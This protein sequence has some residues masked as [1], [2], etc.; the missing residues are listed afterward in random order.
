MPAPEA[1]VPTETQARVAMLE[2]G[3]RNV[4]SWLAEQNA[5]SPAFGWRNTDTLSKEQD[6]HDLSTLVLYTKT[7]GGQTVVVLR[8]SVQDM[9]A[10]GTGMPAKPGG[11]VTGRRAG[12]LVRTPATPAQP[13]KPYDPNF[14][15]AQQLINIIK[16][17]YPDAN[18]EFQSGG[19]VGR[20]ESGITSVENLAAPVVS[21]ALSAFPGQG[22]SGRLDPNKP[23]A[24]QLQDI[25]HVKQPSLDELYTQSLTT[26]HQAFGIE[27]AAAVGLKPTDPGYDTYTNA[28]NFISDWYLNPLIIAGKVGEGLHLASRVPT[29]IGSAKGLA[30]LIYDWRGK[31][32]EELVTGSRW[33]NKVT[34]DLHRVII[35]NPE[36]AEEALVR[37]FGFTAN[38][39]KLMATSRSP[40]DVADNLIDH[41]RGLSKTDVSTLL[42]R[43]AEMQRQIASLSKLR[44]EPSGSNVLDLVG[45]RIAA[46]ETEINSI[47]AKLRFDPALDTFDPLRELPKLKPQ[48]ALMMAGKE[49]FGDTALGQW[50]DRHIL[51]PSDLGLPENIGSST[52]RFHIPLPKTRINLNRIMQPVAASRAVR[53]P[54]SPNAIRGDMDIFRVNAQATLADY[55]VSAAEQAKVL[56]LIV[57]SK[58]QQEIYNVMTHEFANA[59]EEATQR[60]LPS[61]RRESLKFFRDSFTVKQWGIL[62]KEGV[63]RA[64]K[65]YTDWEPLFTVETHAPDGTVGIRPQPYLRSHLA[66]EFMFPSHQGILD[67]TGAWRR[68][69][70]KVS[71]K[72]GEK[73]LLDAWHVEQRVLDKVTAFWKNSIL[74]GRPIAV[75]LRTAGEESVR[76]AAAGLAS[77]VNRPWEWMRFVYNS[78]ERMF[79]LAKVTDAGRAATAAEKTSEIADL[80]WFA[81]RKRNALRRERNIALRDDLANPLGYLHN[82]TLRDQVRRPTEGLPIYLRA[83]DEDELTQGFEALRSW[84]YSWH[85][86]ELSR[87]MLQSG[88]TEDMIA[89]AKTEAGQ[90]YLSDVADLWKGYD[91]PENV[92]RAEATGD[93]GA[94][95]KE[96]DRQITEA[97]G[98]AGTEPEGGQ[99]VLMRA[100]R[101]RLAAQQIE[102]GAGEIAGLS[103]ARLRYV[104]DTMREEMDHL[105]GGSEKIK[106]GILHGGFYDE[107]PIQMIRGYLDQLATARQ[108]YRDYE[109]LAAHTETADEAQRVLQE[110]RSLEMDAKSALHAMHVTDRDLARMGENLTETGE[111]RARYFHPISTPEYGRSL[112]DL[113]EIGDWK[114]PAY[115]S[116]ALHDAPAA[117]SEKV[118]RGFING[119]YEKFLSGPESFFIR[120]PLG[121]QLAR[122]RYNELRKLGWSKADATTEGARWGMEQARQ[123]LYDLSDRTSAQTFARHLAPFLPAWQEILTTW[124]WKLPKRYYPVVGQ[125]FLL[126]RAGQ[127]K[128]LAG[129]LGIDVNAPQVFGPLGWV[130][131]Q[132][133]GAGPEYKGVFDPKKLNL[134]AQ[135]WM[136]G[137]GPIPAATVGT[138]AK[139]FPIIEPIARKLLPYGLDVQLGPMSA[140]MAYEGL[141]HRP[142]PWELASI[143]SQDARYA[144]AKF[145][146]IRHA[147]VTLALEGTKPPDPKD[148]GDD[149]NAYNEAKAD[150]VKKLTDKANH[151]VQWWFI[152][153]SAAATFFPAPLT[154]TDSY[155]EDIDKFYT[156]IDGMSQ[157]SPEAEAAWNRWLEDHPYGDFYR[158]PG[159]VPSRPI[160]Q[161]K[162]AR[163]Q[164]DYQR[165]AAQVQEGYRRVLTDQ[166]FINL[167]LGLSSRNVYNNQLQHA[168]DDIG[169][170]APA[171][172]EN[173]Y[174]RSNLI[175]SYNADWDRYMKYNTDFAGVWNTM[176]QDKHPDSFVGYSYQLDKLSEFYRAGKELLTMD[177]PNSVSRADLRSVLGQMGAALAEANT[178]SGGKLSGLD[179]WFN[180]VLDPY[181][182]H[183]GKLYDQA[184][185]W[186]QL[187]SPERPDAYVKFNLAMEKIREFKANQEKQVGPDGLAYPTP[188]RYYWGS[189]PE[190]A[191]HPGDP[192]QKS[193]ITDWLTL[194]PEW[195]HAVPV[196]E[197][198]LRRDRGA[199][200]DERGHRHLRRPHEHLYRRPQRVPV[201]E[202]VGCASVPAPERPVEVRGRARADGGASVERL[203]LHVGGADD[204]YR[205]GQARRH[206]R[207]V[208]PAGNHHDES[209]QGRGLRGLFF[210]GV[211]DGPQAPVLLDPRR[212][213]QVERHLPVRYQR[214]SGGARERLRPSGSA[215]RRVRRDLLR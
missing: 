11:E 132:S 52:W 71:W 181:S 20:I 152:Y 35:N 149:L 155:K 128:T 17:V 5:M 192:D 34:Q 144:Y 14:L 186:K 18:I 198:R 67:I 69:L 88:S 197:D 90:D 201:L 42:G 165:T 166:E 21:R 157:S 2:P 22:A 15:R 122:Q 87:E 180:K 64:G 70:R 153:R 10:T 163:Y 50:F 44:S 169:K 109:T 101:E 27:A 121:R 140:N 123:L 8:S 193:L 79:D 84:H 210:V 133:L 32:V 196:E 138:I 30:G 81:L 66:H 103:E 110:S 86:D 33:G 120:K 118:R 131:N 146:A 6:P 59:I 142:P 134:V 188:E 203:Q 111:F 212:V 112:R 31:S 96:L 24:E 160:P 150:Y 204:R 194:K 127:L 23:V 141:F 206:F 40:V 97:V 43:K 93:V 114:A 36:G 205:M 102:H 82:F 184:D 189:R 137:L 61:A 195:L 130:L 28:V 208:G 139:K 158:T 202:R 115:V 58:S 73:S 7:V 168:L 53:V 135:S 207:P 72:G 75:L 12:E 98:R 164:D 62:D 74:L 54:F 173:W 104:F 13:P 19:V 156:E 172:L 143:E 182:T 105:T 113:S 55:G 215:L 190:V 179:W 41:F 151:I 107:Q 80:P 154:V 100:E 178:Y 162:F 174:K 9:I 185:K 106:Q 60:M 129:D 117:A 25:E 211:R 183:L 89:W 145:D 200:Q 63:S 76:A 56:S 77:P 4:G 26:T 95:I 176:Y 209:D 167:G 78:E 177:T 92:T 124:A 51:A 48:S 46:Y 108:R 47:D 49:A 175:A 125:A 170:N 68:L 119:M 171:L 126:T 147:R 136:P 91:V 65:D 191:E 187:R 16:T 83:K 213:V 39:A 85:G 99:L 29:E 1:H 94:Q 159:S 37:Q 45:E 57:R 3:V 214:D 199:E 38:Q 148:F 161:Q 116:G